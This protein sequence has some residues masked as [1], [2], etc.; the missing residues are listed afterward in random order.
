MND[1][2]SLAVRQDEIRKWLEAPERLNELR[3]M[4]PDGMTPERFVRTVMTAHLRNPALI[5][6]SLESKWLAIMDAAA[7]GLE[8]DG[9]MAHLVPFGQVAQL[10]VD[11]KGLIQAAYKH[12]R[13]LSI[14]AETVHQDDDFSVDYGTKPSITHRR[15][16][17]PRGAVIGAYATALIRGGGHPFVYLDREEIEAHRARSRAKDKGPWTTDYAAMCKKTAVKQLAKF[18]PQSSQLMTALAAEVE[19]EQETPPHLYVPASASVTEVL[20]AIA[21]EETA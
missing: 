9:R 17:D 21:G 13:V 20:D 11:Y 18:I 5:P 4:L 2:K 15:N 7:I 16:K 10:I 14:S 12:P 3:K 1:E 19:P 8:L 6:C